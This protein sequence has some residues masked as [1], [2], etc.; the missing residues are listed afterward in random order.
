MNRIFPL[1]RTR[2]IVI[3]ELEKELLLYDLEKNKALC[4]NE[5]AASVWHFC[6]GKKTVSDIRFILSEKWQTII[7]EELIW[8]TLEQ[9]KRNDLLEKAAEFPFN[10][11]GLNRREAV[12]KVGLASLIALPMISTVI[13]PSAINAQ[14]LSNCLNPGV[15]VATC[16][17]NAPGVCAESCATNPILAQ[18]CCSNRATVGTCSPSQFPGNIICDCIC[19]CPVN[20]QTC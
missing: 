2:N 16:G 13:A 4:L 11:G 15:P 5:T 7:P 17:P 19:D 6:D 14:S 20:Q 9:F 3:Q 12:K 10:F 1:A 8:L 18:R